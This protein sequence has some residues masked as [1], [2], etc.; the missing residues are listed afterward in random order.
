MNAASDPRLKESNSDRKRVQE[1][2]NLAFPIPAQRLGE[3]GVAPTLFGDDERLQNELGDGGRQQHRG[4]FG[5]AGP[6]H[7]SPSMVRAHVTRPRHHRI[8][9]EGAM[10]TP[11]ITS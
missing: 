4:H 8:T 10:P 9:P 7:W 2:R 1:G 3:P 5:R 6:H 11:R